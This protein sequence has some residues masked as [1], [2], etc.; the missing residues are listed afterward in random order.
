M[1]IIQSFND[2]SSL[3]H[4]QKNLPKIIIK[5][6][7]GILFC[8]ILHNA[9]CFPRAQVDVDFVDPMALS[10]SFLSVHGSS[11]MSQQA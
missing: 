3:C 5:T 2:S 11:F 6:G 4:S 9:H 8:K 1:G 10:Q 7:H